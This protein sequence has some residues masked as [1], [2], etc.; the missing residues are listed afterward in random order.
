MQGS[1]KAH[2]KS[3]EGTSQFDIVSDQLGYF[4]TVRRMRPVV[5]SWNDQ[6]QGTYS[7]ELRHLSPQMPQEE[8]S[9]VTSRLKI[10][11]EQATMSTT[12]DFG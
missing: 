1:T 8:Q 7:C 4:Q 6:I 5:P 11:E 2:Y 10:Q 12:Y 9:E 3:K